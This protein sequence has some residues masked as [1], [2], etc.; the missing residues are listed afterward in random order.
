[1]NNETTHSIL[2]QLALLL[3]CFLAAVL[4]GAVLLVAI[5]AIPSSAVL[6]NVATAQ[7]IY[8][9]QDIRE[10]VI[11]G[12]ETTL[13]DNF[14]DAIMLGEACFD[15]NLDLVP[16]AF[17]NEYYSPVGKDGELLEPDL[18]LIEYI[19]GERDGEAYKYSR[20]WHG[21]LVI[22]KPLLVFFSFQNILLLNYL[23][24][25]ILSLAFLVK[26]YRCRSWVLVCAALVMFFYMSS[27]VIGLTL[28]F[29]WV[30][31]ISLGAAT[32]ILHWG[33]A[34]VKRH[35][36]Y[37]IFLLIGC[38]T[39][40]FDL[41][42]YPIFALALPAVCLLYTLEEHDWKTTTKVILACCLVWTIGYA[43]MWA[44]KWL[45]SSLILGEN[46]L[47]FES[48]AQRASHSYDDISFTYLEVLQENFR[49]YAN[50]IYG[51]LGLVVLLAFLVYLV[52]AY[53]N[54]E[55]KLNVAIV[56]PYLILAT[57]PFVWLFVSQNHAYIHYWMTF[58]NFGF[59][60]L[61]IAVGCLDM[62]GLRPLN[63]P[64]VVKPYKNTEKFLRDAHS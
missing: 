36:Q 15:S 56:V 4:V 30:F 53:R 25:S 38:A 59:F 5:Y 32:C 42:T 29:S 31:Y 33:N 24:V 39:S 40:Y 1:M 19:N 11:P 26:C 49:V 45:L 61:L 3:L 22:L 58:R 51:V 62:L 55:R 13:K 50:R 21:Y 46:L 7:E 35:L 20:Y 63:S 9:N 28:Q 10:R 57:I 23:L 47:P 2:K 64:Y 48:I 12:V 44:A 14:T 18:A 41:L 8:E 37:V 17:T 43:G 52:H 27:F 6:D 54:S 60:P 16:R 34:L